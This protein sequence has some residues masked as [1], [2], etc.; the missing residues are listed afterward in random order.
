MPFQ[1]QG[2]S[3]GD[4]QRVITLAMHVVP[5]LRAVSQLVARGGG[6]AESDMWFGDSAGPWMHRLS[7]TLNRMATVVNLEQIEVRFR[8]LKHRK[9]DFAA[10][11]RPA[12]GWGTYTSVQAARGQR[13]LLQLD[14]AW[15]ETPLW[16]TRT[17]LDSQF[18]TFVHEITHMLLDTDDIAYGQQQCRMLA[19][20]S[21]YAAK[22]NADNWGYFVE[23]CVFRARNP[24]ARPETDLDGLA[25]LF[26]G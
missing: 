3:P 14:T 1:M 24:G 23:E 6:R 11:R 19:K 7:A 26:G 13:F 20:R 22:N 17:A 5:E 25:N 12:G 16:R 18:Q 15:N 9:G 21:P 4:Q 10:A 2:L 8:P